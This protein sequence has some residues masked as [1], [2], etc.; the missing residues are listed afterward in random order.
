MNYTYRKDIN[1][2]K[3]YDLCGGCSKL[4]VL[5]SQQIKEK[6]EKVKKYYLDNN[7]ME[8]PLSQIIESPQI[9]EYRNHM[10]LSFGDL[11]IDG[12][13]QLGLHPRGKQY[14][15]VTID[16]CYI[17]DQDFRKIIKK[18][19]DY[20]R[21]TELKKYHVKLK[22]G[23]LRNLKIRKG[24]NTNEILINLVTTSQ[25]DVDLRSYI[26]M[27]KELDYKGNLVGLIHTVN[28]DYA[29]AVKS[30]RV[31]TCYGRDYFF[32]KLSDY[33]FKIS[34]LDFFQVNTKAAEKL[35][36]VVIDYFKN[37]SLQTVYDL[38]SGT[39]SIAQI[40]SPYVEK[41]IGVEIDQ[42]AVERA[43][44]NAKLNHIN[45]CEFIQGDVRKILNNKEIKIEKIVV[46]PPRPG[47]H[48]EVI[49]NI[50]DMSPQEIVYISCNP[51]TQAQDLKKLLYNNYH[52][53]DIKLIDMFPHTSHIESVALIVKD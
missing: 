36:K 39:G 53:E 48:S 45:N 34:P 40:V 46:D 17:I 29:D 27:M 21:K 38:Y 16:S 13:L 51:K 11:E 10:E 28:D 19:V 35:L 50:V 44:E 8:F 20:F 12:K 1:I 24:H 31:I 26:D 4:D 3:H 30:D 14:D 37:D 22:K 43:R 42:S 15:V 49:K 9:Y 6:K 47:L 7:I 33:K 23:Y 32:E 18:T 25:S 2:C 5:Y 41:I 52:I